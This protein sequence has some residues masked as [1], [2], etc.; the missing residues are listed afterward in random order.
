MASSVSVA[1]GTGK[2]LAARL[3]VT[4]G[5]T[6]TAPRLACSLVALG[7]AEA[8]VGA[9]PGVSAGA[10]ADAGAGGGDD[11]PGVTG[12]NSRRRGSPR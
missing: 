7:T 5:M 8:G 11:L 1:T 12:Q 9:G 2:I 3:C 4:A 10:G 6:P